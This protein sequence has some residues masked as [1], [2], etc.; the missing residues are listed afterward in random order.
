MD[1]KGHSYVKLATPGAPP[2]P[3]SPTTPPAV[4]STAAAPAN[5]ADAAAPK[6]SARL[7][8]HCRSGLLLQLLDACGAHEIALESVR[9]SKKRA[10]R[11]VRQS[12][13][14]S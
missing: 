1:R 5:G 14:G 2:P 4:P 8:G 6:R 11:I 3:P 12:H 9:E 13:T 7:S 10:P